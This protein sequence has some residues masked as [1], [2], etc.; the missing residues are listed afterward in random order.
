MQS[1]KL[2]GINP[3]Q[4]CRLPL[5]VKF[6]AL[7]AIA[8]VAFCG[9]NLMAQ[10]CPGSSSG[11]CFPVTTNGI[12]T[13]SDQ[14]EM[15]T[16]AGVTDAQI[17]FFANNFVGGQKQTATQVATLRGYNSNFMMLHYRL[18]EMLGYGSCDSNGN[19]TANS[20]LTIVDTPSGDWGIEWPWADNTDNP[21]TVTTPYP[22][23]S[24]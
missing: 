17:Q 23:G 15:S 20:P 18:A 1:R 16:S 24:P 12:Y 6:L 19:P 10:I 4:G 7:A 8:L 13:Y 11:R 9:V 14:V 2:R 21:Q 3:I 22:G 5:Q